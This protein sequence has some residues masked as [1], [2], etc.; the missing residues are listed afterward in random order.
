MPIHLV[1]QGECL[2]SIAAA[3]AV[4]FQ[5]ILDHPDNA[6][7][8]DEGRDP[9]ILRPDEK[10]AIPSRKDAARFTLETGRLHKF[11]VKQPQVFLH[12]T[13]E[14]PIGEPL[15][16][17]RYVLEVGGRV[18]EGQTDGNGELSEQLPSTAT[19]AELT[20]SFNDGEEDVEVRRTVNIGGLDP[21]ED[22][23]G[24]QARLNNLGYFCGRT[25]GDLGSLSQRALR[26]F[27]RDCG[28]EDDGEA[29]DTARDEL[30][31]ICKC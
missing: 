17:A 7:L 20:L 13:F 1:K 26:A 10:I 8:R 18:F 30:R 25:D 15:A 24:I 14:D 23:S 11:V 4:R 12:L 5:D 21:V 31:R 2:S 9:N 3:Y 28:L 16:G 19:S 6:S 27:K 22:N 29:P